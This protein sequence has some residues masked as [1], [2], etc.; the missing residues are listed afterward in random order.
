MAE[1]IDFDLSKILNFTRACSSRNFPASSAKRQK[2]QN[3]LSIDNLDYID[4]NENIKSNQF[5]SPQSLPSTESSSPSESSDISR[6]TIAERSISV[7]NGFP[8][9]PFQESEFFSQDN[10]F[11]RSTTDPNIYTFESSEVRLLFA[12][13]DIPLIM[14]KNKTKYGLKK[15]ELLL[16]M[17]VS[18]LDWRLIQKEIHIARELP[19]NKRPENLIITG[20][21]VS[22]WVQTDDTNG[23]EP[24]IFVKLNYKVELLDSIFQLNTIDLISSVHEIIGSNSVIIPT[25]CDESFTNV[26]INPYDP[27]NPQLFYTSISENTMKLPLVEEQFDIPELETQLLRFQRKTVKWLLQKEG[28][29]YDNSSNRCKPFDLISPS[30]RVKLETALELD[31]YK[32][33]R[34]LDFEVHVV[35]SKLCFGWTLIQLSHQTYWFNCYT[36]NISS[37][38]NVY[39]TLLDY[40]A[41]THSPT[42]TEQLPAQGLLAEEMGLGK[43]VEITALVIL[44]QRPIDQINK[45]VQ[46]TLKPYGD[47][48]TIP[49]SRTT[50]I[51]SPESILRQWV[52][53]IVRLAPSLAVT[54]YKGIDKY[55]KLNKNP[56]LIAEYLKGFDVVFTTYGTIS[57]ELEYANYSSTKKKTRS[58]KRTHVWVDPDNSSVEGGVDIDG[59]EADVDDAH[60]NEIDLLK[61]YQSLFQLSLSS[62]KDPV[63]ANQKSTDNQT[64]TDYEK[65][66]QDEIQLAIKHNRGLPDNYRNN[67]H[68]DYQT[69]LMLMQFWRVVLDEVQMVSSSVSRAFQSAALIPKHHSWGVSGTPIK[70]NFDDLLS[71]LKFLK[72]QPFGEE[73]YSKV[74]WQMLTN[75]NR[76]TNIHGGNQDFIKLWSQ[77]ALR[78]TKA[79][80]HDDI[81]LPPQNRVLMSIP[82]NPVEQENYNQMLEGCLATICLDQYGNPVVADWEPSSTI[83]THMRYWLV[84][85]RQVCCNPQVGNLNLSSRR[86]KSRNHL[87]YGKTGQNLAIQ[88][89]KTL[90]NVLDDMIDRAHEQITETEKEKVQLY[91]DLAEYKDYLLMP[92]DALLTLKAGVWDAERIVFRLKRYLEKLISDYKS[93]LNSNGNNIDTLGDSDQLGLDNE[94]DD[95]FEKVNRTNAKKLKSGPLSKY[96]DKINATRIKLRMWN[97]TLHKYYFLIA[98]S[99][100]QCYDE[101]YQKKVQN[102]KFSNLLKTIPGIE[103]M[104][105]VDKLKENISPLICGVSTDDLEPIDSLAGF[106]GD[107]KSSTEVHQFQEQFFYG[108]AEKVREK[109]LESTIKGVSK[110]VK[111]RI[112]SRELYYKDINEIS[113][114][115]HHH[116]Q[117]SSKKL[118]KCIPLIDLESLEDNI[119]GMRAKIFFDHV[120]ILAKQLNEQA[121]VLNEWMEALIAILCKPLLMHDKTPDGAEYEESIDD[122][123][124]VSCYL[125]V[126]SGLIA[127]RS[128]FVLGTEL[129]N[130]SSTFKKQQETF[131]QELSNVNNREF[132]KDLQDKREQFKPK[133]SNTLQGLALKVSSIEQELYGGEDEE[134]NT[135]TT[136]LGNLESELF[137]QFSRRVRMIFENQKLAEVLI[138]KELVNCNS[139]FNSRIEY[140]KQL[141]QISDSV[142]SSYNFE[143]EVDETLITPLCYGFVDSNREQEAKLTKSI[144]KYRYLQSLVKS[145][146]NSD[147]NASNDEDDLMCTICRSSITIGSLT[148]CGHKYCK[149]CLEHWLSNSRTCP[150][151][152]AHISEMTI[153]NFTHHRPNLKVNAVHDGE[154][155]GGT[156][157]N[158]NGEPS[159]E[160]DLIQSN[161]TNLHSIYKSIDTDIVESIQRIELKTSYS[162][163]VDMIIK[164]VLY[165]K[166]KDP[167]VQIVIFSQWQDLLYIIG[168]ALKNSNVSYLASH[169][170]FTPE[171]GGGR[172]RY[173]YDSVEEFKRSGSEITCFLLNAR[174][175]ASGLTLINATHIFLCEPLVNTSLELQAISRI[176]RIGQSKETTVWMFAIENTI[177]ES[178]VLM[179]TNKRLQYFEQKK[180]NALTEIDANSDEKDLSKAESMTMT[181]SGGIDT[182]VNKNSVEGE[183]VTNSDLWNAFFSATAKKKSK[184]IISKFT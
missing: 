175:Q 76:R 90:E 74:T 116:L 67:H 152:K 70:K 42:S 59:S 123:D 103:Q 106:Q 142:R 56:N 111:Y 35:L 34:D 43:T 114:S 122:Q 178:I 177:E 92:E 148:Q 97:V 58:T 145:G 82:F 11:T 40:Y 157:G 136:N 143:R 8:L 30:L 104:N 25:K 112:T 84:K 138:Q 171:M 102:A 163:K 48:K 36:G 183:L 22:F 12:G 20:P 180:P 172:R 68:R 89:L 6:I 94:S 4:V 91:I 129:S 96:E 29:K 54:V 101:E 141:Q 75:T 14:V 88:S 73:Y 77:I 179:S 169:G 147:T 72:F 158:A 53:E 9:S 95:E 125:H 60:M 1:I 108:L 144:A 7:G 161:L 46:I 28:V 57:N 113:D 18:E 132:L 87:F 83:L 126:L 134:K 19:P 81:K 105:K 13:T 176:H 120:N 93:A 38:R 164:Q 140:F 37:K 130:K 27:I 168:T 86:Y 61:E 98:S 49:K 167:E 47:L 51:I 85:L 165:L 156:N 26:E 52:K 182:L 184:Q 119:L 159:G 173:Q 39:K 79:M 32:E 62:K 170:T 71:I 63:N 174:A 2:I 128:E 55:P 78:H 146:D 154:S 117:K 153:Y 118:F 3:Q 44:N 10:G 69:P 133:S 166:N 17:N 155:G 21:S 124:K 5:I 66:L 127:D 23:S 149:D 139:V 110:A 162:S 109:I 115:G 16:S 151:C 160:D 99:H 50:L 131:T 137:S 33:D 45:P 41:T 65:A 181:K 15:T 107:M 31:E 121:K 135:D 100:F 24:L 64:E 80:V 150:M